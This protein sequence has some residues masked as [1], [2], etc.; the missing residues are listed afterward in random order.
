MSQVFRIGS[1]IGPYDPFWVQV[2]EAVNQKVQQL[3]LELIPIEIDG[4][5]DALPAEEQIGVVEELLAQELDALICWSFPEGMIYQILNGGLPVVYL[6]EAEIRHP[7]FVSPRGFYEAGQMIGDY[8]AEHL[9]GRGHV[10]CI[11]GLSEEPGREDGRT[12]INGFYDALRDFPGISID[13]TPSYWR[14]EQAYPQIE[15]VLKQTKPPIDAVFG[16]SD[17]IALAARD[18]LRSFGWM[19]KDTLIAGVNGDP[20]ALAALAEGSLSA[21]VETSPLEFGSQAVELACRA[22]RK[23][24]LPDYFSFQP[25][26]V[27]AENLTEVALQKLLAIADLPTRL[28]GVNRQLEQNRLTQMETSAAINRHVGGLLDRHQLSHEI[29]DSIRDNYGYDPVQLFMWSQEDEAFILEQDNSDESPTEKT[30]IPLE[31]SGI[32]GEALRRNEPVF[33]PDTRYSSRFPPDPNWP[34]T[35]SRVVLPIRLGE[36][37][38]G[39]LDLHSR[40]HTVH[41][42]QE[43]VGLQPLADQLGIAIRNAE[44]YEEA[45]HARAVAEKADRLKTRLLAN[46]GHELRAPLNVILGYSQTALSKPNP[47]EIELPDELR[48]DIGYIFRSCEHLTRLINDLLDLSRA[49]IDQLDLFPEMI[50]TRAFLEEV[51]YSMANTSPGEVAWRL[52]LPDRLPV[53]QADPVRLRQILLNLLNNASKF[54]PSGQIVLGAAVEP[55]H[56][57][58][59]VQDTGLGIPVELQER[60]FEPFATVERLGHRSGGIG[61]GLSITR[62]LVALH[63]GVM[64]LESQTGQGSTFHVYLPL[65]NLSGKFSAPPAGMLKPVL[66]LLSTGQETAQMFLNLAAQMRLPIRKISAPEQL[67]TILKET[68]PSVLA[69]DML[70]ARRDEWELLEHIRGHPQLCQLPFIVYREEAGDGIET[71]EVLMKPVAG[72]TLLEAINALRPARETGPILIVDDEAEARDF[73]QRLVNEA[74]PGYPVLSAENG[75]VA[76]ASMEETVP[77]LVILDLMMPEVDG[78]MVLEKMRSRSETRQV[79]VLVMSGKLLSLEDIQRLDYAR[80][81][82]QSKE[83]LSDDE[84]VALLRKILEPGE[85]LPQPT[86]ILVKAAIAYLHQNYALPVTRQEIAQAVGVSSNYLSRIFRQEVGLSAWDCLNRFRI[87]KARELLLNST[88]TITVIATQVGFDDSAYFSRVFRKHTGQSPQSYRQTEK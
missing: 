61:L 54:T 17:P 65:P 46:V 63:G 5:P 85:A 38:L 77:S 4:R 19:R 41:L 56:L 75:T 8:F 25:R 33:I 81:T 83:L 53:I 78:F 76:L 88:D 13:H 67:D 18:V 84:A 39:L 71:T 70:N 47:Y 55:P 12:R 59:W 22:A 50:S 74:L 51:F 7:R 29:T 30:V 36:T 28:V 66:L 3:G 26:L 58:L 9:E 69:Q 45:V 27:T 86:S 40:H 16:L 1:Q 60:I 31:R 34:D 14:Y 44:L 82:F 64:S 20:L 35:L 57:H 72:K 79:P 11:G 43:L 2:R 23:E 87:R 24:V 6:S 42:R 32:L 73:Y 52:W 48:R 10:L 21:T 49:E 15:A 80:V 37:I 68:T 62:R